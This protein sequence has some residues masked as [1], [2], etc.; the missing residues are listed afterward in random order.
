MLPDIYDEQ[1]LLR[2]LVSG[3]EYAFARIFDRY[4]NRVYHTANSFLKSPVSAEEVVQDIF[5][6]I[7]LKRSDLD[8]VQNLEAYLGTMTRHLVL[9]RLKKAAYENSGRKAF[10]A[11]QPESIA[12]TD[13][14]L[15]NRQCEQ[16]LEA[17]INLLPERQKQVY[18]LARTKG[19]SHE[20]IAIRLGI[21]KLTVK[22]HMAEALQAIRKHLHDYI[23][24]Y[25][26]VMLLFP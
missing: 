9:D 15:R 23:S 2:L 17:A 22:K 26:L 19:L 6:K 7:W 13:H 14:L 8:V 20:M 4:H 21:S 12:T 1:R 11:Y 16:L 18:R 24:I 25:V 5:L 10:T 3:S